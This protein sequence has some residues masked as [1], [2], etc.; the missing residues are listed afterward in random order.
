[1]KIKISRWF[2][3]ISI[4]IL[5][6]KFIEIFIRFK[7]R[8]FILKMTTENNIFLNLFNQS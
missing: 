5:R 8:Q 2:L 3:K 1:M 4:L 7:E 6:K